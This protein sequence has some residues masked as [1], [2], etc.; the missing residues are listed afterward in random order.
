MRQ[1]AGNTTLSNAAR[2]VLSHPPVTP[3]MAG[4]YARSDPSDFMGEKFTCSA[5]KSNYYLVI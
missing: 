2:T 4:E 1:P 3:R 5:W